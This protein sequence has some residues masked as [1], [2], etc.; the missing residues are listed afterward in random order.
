MR[1]EF[2]YEL[3]DGLIRAATLRYLAHNL[4]WWMPTAFVLSL[5]LLIPL[6]KT[7]DG[8]MCALYTAA[9][10][11]LG[12]VLVVI[13]V[14]S[15]Q[16]G[17]RVARQLQ[18]RIA[19]C[20]ISDEGLRLENALAVSTIKWPL[21]V[22]LIRGRVAWLFVAANHQYFALPAEKLASD[23]RAFIESRIAATGGRLV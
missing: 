8:A 6:C 3:S 11:S 7:S 19:R 2:S 5:L 22:K 20:T 4:G 13:Y 15:Y 18:S 16:R 10:L 14:V 12:I 1:H 9:V 21:F 23:V 17:L